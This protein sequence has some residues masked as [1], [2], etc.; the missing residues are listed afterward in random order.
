MQPINNADFIIP[1]EIEDQVHQ[2]YVLK[3]PGMF[4][5][6]TLVLWFQFFFFPP[7]W[8]GLRS[9]WYLN[10]ITTGVDKFMKRVGEL[11]EVVIFTASLAKVKNHEPPF[12]SC[13]TTSSSPHEELISNS[14]LLILF[15]F[16]LACHY[17]SLISSF[18]LLVCRS[19]IRSAGQIQSFPCTTLSRSMCQSQGQLRQGL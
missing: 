12:Y 1:V 14:I 16:L 8:F 9:C 5:Y 19:G 10:E 3:R 11:F 4:M 13:S 17:S 18:E 15:Y 6:R 7:K 2:V